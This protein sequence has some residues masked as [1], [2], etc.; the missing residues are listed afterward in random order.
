MATVSH[1]TYTMNFE[2]DSFVMPS[3]PINN[4]MH[5]ISMVVTFINPKSILKHKSNILCF[6]WLNYE[7]TCTQWC[8]LV[9]ILGT[10]FA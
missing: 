8:Q 5:S 9:D 1:I 6:R 4:F 7:M 3:T 2:Q 10:M